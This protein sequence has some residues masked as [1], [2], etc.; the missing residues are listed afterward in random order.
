MKYLQLNKEQKYIIKSIQDLPPVNVV[1]ILTKDR[2]DYREGIHI[3]YYLLSICLEAFFSGESMKKK[4]NEQLLTNPKLS[5][6]ELGDSGLLYAVAQSWISFYELINMGWLEIEEYYIE[7]KIDLP[8]NTPGETL[9]Y[10]LNE[11]SKHQFEVCMMDYSESSPKRLY[12]YINKNKKLEKLSSLTPIQEKNRKTYVN[13]VERN[14]P[15]GK[16]SK[17][18]ELQQTILDICINSKDSDIRELLKNY[19][20]REKKAKKIR[21]RLANRNHFKEQIWT[22]G[23]LIKGSLD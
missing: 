11:I 10:I 12:R 4:V 9:T 5:N 3:W 8:T 18:H 23:N 7:N 19:Q 14:I 1:I 16:F 2:D 21:M 15:L 6:S 20:S 17:G 22:K 13:Y